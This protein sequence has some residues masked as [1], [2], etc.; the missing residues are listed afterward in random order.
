MSLSRMPYMESTK[1]CG[2]VAA[3][4]QWLERPA[5]E[6]EI[7]YKRISSLRVMTLIDLLA[8]WLEGFC[9]QNRVNQV[10]APVKHHNIKPH[11]I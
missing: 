1:R 3:G 4:S 9:W 10:G 5:Q 7:V 8:L 11:K 6:C 2:Y